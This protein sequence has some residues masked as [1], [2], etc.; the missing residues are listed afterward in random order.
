MTDPD[1]VRKAWA[2]RVTEE[3]EGWPA[4]PT[5]DAPDDPSARE[6]T[7]AAAVRTPADPPAGRTA[8]GWAWGDAEGELD[9]VDPRLALRQHT[10]ETARALREERAYWG[11]DST[12][13]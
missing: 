7:G 8:S 1:E 6:S 2:R 5:P 4:W 12:D 13:G 9:D 10:G 11:L 3:Y